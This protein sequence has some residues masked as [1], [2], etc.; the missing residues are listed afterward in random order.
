MGHGL[1]RSGFIDQRRN[2]CASHEY[3]SKR[4]HS[5]FHGEHEGTMDMLSGCP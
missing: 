4:A 5:V 1:A 3:N 2:A